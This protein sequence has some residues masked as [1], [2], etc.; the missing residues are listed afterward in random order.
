MVFRVVLAKS[1]AFRR[2][3][4]GAFEFVRTGPIA[5]IA[6]CASASIFGLFTQ[7]VLLLAIVVIPFFE[8]RNSL[9]TRS[10]TSFSQHI[11]ESDR[12]STFGLSPR[13]SRHSA[14]MPSHLSPRIFNKATEC[15]QS[16]RIHTEKRERAR[17]FKK[18]LY[19]PRGGCVSH[20]SEASHA[21]AGMFVAIFEGEFGDAGFIELAQAFGDH[22]VVLFLGRARER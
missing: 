16:L 3:V 13:L 9:R 4:A 22:P 11:Q 18:R 8:Q 12:M 17:C 15:Q 21:I 14:S 6:C 10:F 20:H 7:S 1:S 19:N 5:S 2:S